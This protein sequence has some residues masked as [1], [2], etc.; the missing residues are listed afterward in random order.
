[1][2][3]RSFR[4]HPRNCF[5]FI[6]PASWASNNSLVLPL[7]LLIESDTWTAATRTSFT[8]V[9]WLYRQLTCGVRWNLPSVVRASTF[10]LQ[11]S[12]FSEA[13][14]TTQQVLLGCALGY[15][16]LLSLPKPLTCLWQQS[17]A[18][19]EFITASIPPPQD[20]SHIWVHKCTQRRVLRNEY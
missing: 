7:W 2:S 8:D 4:I 17:R 11:L 10:E 6:I 14:W 9:L 1:M 3:I 12:C 20:T 15:A 18:F 5:P 16:Y 19:W 13:A